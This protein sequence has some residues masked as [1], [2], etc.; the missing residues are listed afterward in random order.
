MLANGEKLDFLGATRTILIPEEE[1]A[2]L[3]MKAVGKCVLKER[4]NIMIAVAL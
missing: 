4:V 1:L 3:A 2:S